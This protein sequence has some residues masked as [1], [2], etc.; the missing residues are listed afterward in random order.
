MEEQPFDAEEIAR[1]HAKAMQLCSQREKCTYDMEIWYAR[2]GVPRAYIP[3]LVARL[4]EQKFVSD[5]R[6]AES[7]A[8]EKMRLAG[9]GARKIA[10]MLRSKR[11]DDAVIRQ[12]MGKA[13]D[14]VG[15]ADLEALLEKRMHGAWRQYV[16][17][18]SLRARMLRFAVGRGFEMEESLAA[19]DR[20]LDGRHGGDDA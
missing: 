7:Y 17:T 11:I 16:G 2:K 8:R 4:V 3:M 9:W 15:G 13:E 20:L 14:E 6:Y 1:I 12:A 5:S 18:P 19:V 10:A